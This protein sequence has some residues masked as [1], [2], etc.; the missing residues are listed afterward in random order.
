MKYEAIDRLADAPDT[1]FWVHDL[2]QVLKQK[3]PIDV[4]HALDALIA[5]WDQDVVNAT[6]RNT[7]ATR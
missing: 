2:I 6:L 1:Y 7:E 3:D 5:A 4:S